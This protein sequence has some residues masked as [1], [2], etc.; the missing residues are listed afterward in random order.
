[1][2]HSESSLCV[3]WPSFRAEEVSHVVKSGVLF[4]LIFSKRFMR[5]HVECLLC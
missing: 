1:M 4:I 2:P 3:Y 5:L